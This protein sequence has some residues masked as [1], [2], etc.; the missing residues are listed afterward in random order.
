MHLVDQD[1]HQCQAGACRRRIRLARQTPA[2]TR[3][4]QCPVSRTCS[5][6]RRISKF[7]R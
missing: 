7:K 2:L 4:E 5:K 6:Q 3:E 1:R